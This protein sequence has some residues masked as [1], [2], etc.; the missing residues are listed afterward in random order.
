MARRLVF[1]A[2]FLVLIAGTAGLCFAGVTQPDVT[3]STEGYLESGLSPLTRTS[4]SGD[5]HMTI[6][7]SAVGLDRFRADLEVTAPDGSL[8]RLTGMQGNGFFLLDPGR[9]IVLETSESNSQPSELRIYGLDGRE[10]HRESL[11]APRDLTLSLDGRYLACGDRDAT[12]VLNLETFDSARYERLDLFTVGPG[13]LLAGISYRDESALRIEGGGT[14]ARRVA[15]SFRARR[16]ALALDGTAAYLLGPAAL[17]R[18][19]VGSAAQRDE[20]FAPQTIFEARDGAE[21]QDLRLTANGFLVGLRTSDGRSVQGVLL[22][23]DASGR[24]VGRELGPSRQISGAEMSPAGTGRAPAEGGIPWPILP[25][26]QHPVGNTYGEYQDYGGAPYPHGGFDVMGSP[27]QAVYAVRGGVVKAILTTSA[28]YHWRVAVADSAVAGSCLGYLYAHLNQASITVHVGDVITAGQLLGTL[29]PWPIADFTHCHFTRLLDS[30]ATWDGSW[31]SV[32][33]PHLDVSH[34]ETVPPVFQPARGT[35][36]LAFCTNET[37]SYQNSLSLHGSVDIIA[38]VSDVI[39]SSWKCAVQELR[40]TIYPQG[41]PG[42][43]VVNDKQSVFFNMGLDGYISGTNDTFLINLFY[44][45]DTVCP[46]QGDYDYREFYHILTNSNGDQIYDASDANQA[47]N[48]AALPDGRYVIRVKAVDAAGNVRA[49]SM[50]VTTVN[51][52]PSTAEDRSDLSDR[53]TCLPNPVTDRATIAFSVPTPGRATLSIYTPSGRLL[54]RL[55]AGPFAAGPGT[56][57]WDRRDARGRRVPAGSYLYRVEGT[58]L[59][60]SGKLVVAR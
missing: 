51:G 27:N 9:V 46:T 56:L 30:G 59:D 34:T 7:P 33:N 15:M 23:L 29:V 41:Q 31:L 19:P 57:V 52:N 8:H 4:P 49:D 22:T 53:L 48:T 43:P 12:I 5:Y 50:I 55:Q 54:R 42:S 17:V 47:W 1:P 26:S 32:S 21:L 3:V 35:E 58:G 28:E 11:E 36:L 45:Q 24:P 40:Y 6:L 38:R 37:S 13:G 20:S 14:T 18:V 39:A 2:A 10:L 60:R 44:K 25:D 16:I